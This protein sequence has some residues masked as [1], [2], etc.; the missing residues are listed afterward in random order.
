MRDGHDIHEALGEVPFRLRGVVSEVTSNC[1]A[2]ALALS[3]L[4]QRR[5]ERDKEPVGVSRPLMG[6]R[7]EQER[8]VTVKAADL[9]ALYTALRGLKQEHELWVGE[10]YPQAE[11]R[12]RGAFCGTGRDLDGWISG[13]RGRASLEDARDVELFSLRRGHSSTRQ[14]GPPA[15]LRGGYR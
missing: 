4:A 3:D 2:M 11:R 6:V 5:Q 15:T 13:Q 8:M 1:D 10:G 12:M 14:A 7:V 9:A